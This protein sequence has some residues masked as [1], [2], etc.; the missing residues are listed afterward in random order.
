[1]SALSSPAFAAA[2]IVARTRA[3]SADRSGHSAECALLSRIYRYGGNPYWL[4]ALLGSDGDHGETGGVGL[5]LG[6]RGICRN[7]AEA[8]NPANQ[9]GMPL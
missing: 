8:Q 9:S 2:S 1:M 3:P 4:G 6:A 5:E 7:A